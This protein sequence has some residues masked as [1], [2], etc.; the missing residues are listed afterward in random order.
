M[1][2]KVDQIVGKLVGLAPEYLA[3]DWD[4]IGLQIGSM[5]N[6]ISKIL[7]ALDA[8]ERVIDEAVE[9]GAN[10]IIVHHP[11]IFN[12]LKKVTKDD[13]IGKSIYKLIKNDISLY[14]MHTNFDAAFGGTNDVLSNII[15]LYNIEG[16][17]ANDDGLGIGRKGDI[18]ATTIEGLA[19]KLKKD[20]NLPYARIVGKPGQEVKKVA[21]CTG[22]GMSYLKH[23]IGL[24]DV[25]ITGDVKFHEA[26]GALENNIGII[27]VGHYGSENIAMPSIKEYMQEFIEENNIEMIVSQINEDPFKI[28]K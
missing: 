6:D 23:A 27:D 20:L 19:H 12:P 14:V 11:M 2:V 16:L 10:M 4:N 22:S 7:V 24:A 9:I 1:S 25:F 26:Q 8:T 5:D 28:I 15:G 18:K 13:P 21:I 3:E 17:T